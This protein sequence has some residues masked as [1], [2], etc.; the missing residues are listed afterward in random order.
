MWSVLS[1]R[2]YCHS[3]R[4]LCATVLCMTQVGV[5]IMPG[6]VGS[7]EVSMQDR[8][9]EHCCS[10]SLVV[11]QILSFCSTSSSVWSV[12]KNLRALRKMLAWQYACLMQPGSLT[13]HRA[14]YA[15]MQL[16]V[17]TKMMSNSLH[18]SQRCKR[19]L[20]RSI[21]FRSADLQ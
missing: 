17:R 4:L 1:T 11:R 9:Y 16:D 19:L 7:L 13:S 6:A 18:A 12:K 21:W 3:H 5:A 14:R 10:K 2:Q 8:Q 15:Y 20:L